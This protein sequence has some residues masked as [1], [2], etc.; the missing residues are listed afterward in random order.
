MYTINELFVEYIPMQD[1]NEYLLDYV[2]NAGQTNSISMT[3]NVETLHKNIYSSE[4]LIAEAFAKHDPNLYEPV[5]NWFG[6][7]SS[8][9]ILESYMKGNFTTKVPANPE[10]VV[11]DGTVDII[12]ITTG[13]SVS[14]NDD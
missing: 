6:A 4:E 13:S 2:D 14:Y 7:K 12:A 3:I 11:P 10:P 1:K 9:K 5:I 8:K